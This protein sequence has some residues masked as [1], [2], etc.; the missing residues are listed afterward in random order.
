MKVLH[1]VG[2]MNL[3]GTESFLM[4]LFRNIDN[5]KCKFEFLTYYEEDELGYFDEEIV[6]MGGVIHRVRPAKYWNAP[7]FISN[8]RE[9]IRKGGYDVVHAHTTYNAG[10]ALYAAY[11][12]NVPVRVVHS[13][14]TNTGNKSFLKE[15]YQFVMKK[16]INT[17]STNYLACSNAAACHMFS[18][19]NMLT[20]RY[21][22]LPN[23]VDLKSFLSLKNKQYVSDFKE[24]L[25]ISQDTKIV[26]HVGR[27]GKA[28]NHDFIIKLFSALTKENSH[29]HLILVG[30]GQSRSLIESYVLNE[31]IQDKVS[32][33]GLRSDISKIMSIMDVFILP[34]LY[35]GFGIVLLEAQ[36][37]GL[38]CIVS[39]NV[40][41]EA[42]L[43][44]GLFEQVPLVDEAKWIS[45]I[46]SNSEMKKLDK[47][48]IE[49]AILDRGFSMKNTIEK[50]MTIY[51]G[52]V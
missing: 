31:G 6:S 30:D 49:N 15:M 11:K 39:E 52:E 5:D 25:N 16:T 23:S 46:I 40:Q 38:P 45:K 12:E 47:K 42:D 37:S 10:F 33:L 41:P 48:I 26:G 28:K 17:F 51:K 13:H 22:F 27:F 18:K 32:F 44:I 35:E 8:I 3:G 36:A 20:D 7:I 34:S 14:N 1:V 29:Y 2:K 43:K 19:K 4:N 9:V 24:E 50:L 21:A